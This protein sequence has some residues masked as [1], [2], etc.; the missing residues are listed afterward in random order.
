M[1]SLFKQGGGKKPNRAIQFTDGN[2]DRR[3]IRLGPVGLVPA[4][5]FKRKVEILLSHCLTNAPLDTQASAWLAGLPDTMYD[6]LVT[7][8]LATPRKLKTAAPML[9]AW[10]RKY[11]GQRKRELMPSSVNKLEQT[12]AKLLHYFPSDLRIDEINSDTASDWRASLVA[13]ELSEATVRLHCRNSKT[14]FNNA[15]EREL[16]PA[17]PFCK[18]PSRAIAAQRDRYVTPA[19]IERLAEACPNPDW[20]VL[21]GLA[22]YAGLRVP[23]ETHSLTWADVDWGRSRLNVRSI[24]TERYEKHRRR[25]VPIVPKLMTI[26]QDTFDAALEGQQGVLR[27]SRNNL[28]RMFETITKRAELER[29]SRCFQVLRQSCET[30]WSQRFPQHAV[31]AWLGHS[32]IVSRDHYLQVTDEMYSKAAAIVVAPDEASAAVN[33]GTDSQSLASVECGCSDSVATPKKN[34]PGDSA[35]CDFVTGPGGIRTPDQAI[36]SRRL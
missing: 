1:A 9:D 17:N 25:S 34:P 32:E 26:L 7:V 22:G 4:R 11:I 28:H 13:G 6:K 21:I 33:T 27:I 29:F 35:K 23:S 31:S 3:T 2:G 15:V 5:E 12:A 19:E 16:I 8:G 10:L 20:R 36:M 14:I 30:E 24:K 18:L